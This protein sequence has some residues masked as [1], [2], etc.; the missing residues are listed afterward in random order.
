MNKMA[1][2]YKTMISKPKRLTV[3]NQQGPMK[4]IYMHVSLEQIKEKGGKLK[5]G[6]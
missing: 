1:N 2:G 4:I 5:E 6:I 3:K